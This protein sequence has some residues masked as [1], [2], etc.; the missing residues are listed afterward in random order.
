MPLS[1]TGLGG[2]AGS[3]FRAAADT[4]ASEFNFTGGSAP[5]GF[6]VASGSSPTLTFDSTGAKFSG[7]AANNAY[8]LRST[9]S[10][11]G[12]YLFQISTR[13]DDAA[14]SWCNDA[15]MG[16]FSSSYTSSNW[17]WA[18]NANIS[19]RKAVQN[20][21]PQP[22]IYGSSTTVNGTSD[23]LRPSPQ[24]QVPQNDWITM[25][26]K[27]ESSINTLSYSVTLGNKDWTQSGTRIQNWINISESWSGTYYWG[28]TCDNDNGNTYIN[29]ARYE[30]L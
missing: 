5:S 16:L 25:H 28:I 15:G 13:I 18:W 7:N 30:K 29:G 12:D 6:T 8:R 24:G 23:L 11:T 14:Q 19:D 26:M 20:N 4:G 3:L 1:M 21:C 22:V 2:G 9:D 27:H 17:E 10:F